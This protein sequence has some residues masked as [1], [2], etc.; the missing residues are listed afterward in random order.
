[1][2]APH[3]APKVQKDWVAMATY[4]LDHTVDTYFVFDSVPNPDEVIMTL[5][6]NGLRV[7]RVKQNGRDFL[8]VSPMQ[9][10]VMEI[11]TIIGYFR[12]GFKSIAIDCPPYNNTLKEALEKLG[13]GVEWE[14]GPIHS[15]LRINKGQWN[16]CE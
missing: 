15:V 6:N 1:M 16:E 14:G 5:E 7:I 10:K 9:E 12:L 4:A 3:Q 11:D 2:A 13:F 8:R